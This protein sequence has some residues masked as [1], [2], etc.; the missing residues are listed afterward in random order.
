[1]D[2]VRPL[3]LGLGCCVVAAFASLLVLAPLADSDID[4]LPRY[5]LISAPVLVGALVGAGLAARVHREPE[6]RD[7]RRHLLAALSGPAAF[8]VSNSIGVAPELDAVWLVRLLNLVLPLTAGYA[9]VRLL[10]HRTTPRIL[11]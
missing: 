11:D 6:R 8:A 4:D 10:D 1:M 2:V 3:V 7:S 9:G 5:L